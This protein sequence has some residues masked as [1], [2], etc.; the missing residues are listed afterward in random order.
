MLFDQVIERDYLS[1]HRI[2]MIDSEYGLLNLFLLG[3]IQ[4]D[5]RS[6]GLSQTASTIAVAAP[7]IVKFHVTP[8]SHFPVVVGRSRGGRRP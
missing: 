4:R 7:P 1:A 2:P 8:G 3:G 5:K 6:R